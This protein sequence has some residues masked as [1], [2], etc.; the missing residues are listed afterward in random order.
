MGF[1]LLSSVSQTPAN[2]VTFPWNRPENG[3][4]IT[5]WSIVFD[6]EQKTIYLKTHQNHSVREFS[7]AQF[8]FN[9]D[10]DYLV[11]NI[12]DGVAGSAFPLFTPFSKEANQ[13]ILDLSAPNIGLLDEAVSGLV[14][15]VDHLYRNRSMT[16]AVSRV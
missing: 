14:E 2:V 6:P 9:A 7:Q 11:M 3:D 1:D 10:G 16:N 4:T 15:A 13:H 12:H 5:A 8:N